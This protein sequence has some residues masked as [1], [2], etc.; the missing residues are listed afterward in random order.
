MSRAG[1]GEGG[2][3]AYNSNAITL[4]SG[5]GSFC[6]PFFLTQNLFFNL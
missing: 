5:T 4:Q 3:S 2:T 6:F 1:G